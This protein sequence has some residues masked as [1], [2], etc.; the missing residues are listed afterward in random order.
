MGST[1][2]SCEFRDILGDLNVR[3]ELSQENSGFDGRFFVI[4][5][6]EKKDEVREY[7]LD[8]LKNFIFFI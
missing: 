4:K 3:G 2:E 1:W 6:R 7:R 8:I 5:E